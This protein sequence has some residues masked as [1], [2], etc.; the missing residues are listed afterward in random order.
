M[1]IYRRRL[2][3]SV[4]ALVS[5]LENRLA[6]QQHQLEE[7]QHQREKKNLNFQFSWLLR[8]IKK[9]TL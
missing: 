2:A 8:E 3:S 1:T 7:Q 6:G 5:T 9:L 4:A